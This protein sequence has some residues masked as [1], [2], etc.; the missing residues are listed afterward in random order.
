MLPN[1]TDWDIRI[2]ASDINSK[3]LDIA[4][5]GLYGARSV[6][7]VPPEYLARYFT[8]HSELEQVNLVIKKMV[9]FRQLNF[10]DATAMNEYRGYD[11]IFC[12]NVLIYF[13]AES[14]TQVLEHFYRTLNSG[15]CIYLGHSES[16]GRIT[17]A[18]KMRRIGENLVYFKP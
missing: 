16:V 3:V 7:D 1:P 15:G 11:V 10:S 18:F 6:K 12:R 13:N 14:R 9:D 17:E 4:R 5:R 2:V 8:N